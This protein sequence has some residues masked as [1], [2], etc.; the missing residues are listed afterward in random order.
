MLLFVI[1]S[2]LGSTIAVLSATSGGGSSGAGAPDGT[3]EQV[4]HGDPAPP[5]AGQVTAR[6]GQPASFDRTV[7][8][9]IAS[10]DQWWA[11]QL[12]ELYGLDYEPLAGGVWGASPGRELPPCGDLEVTYEDVAENAFFCPVDD[13]VV[14]DAESLIPDLLDRYGEAAVGVVLAHEWAHAIQVRVAEDLAKVDQVVLEL[15]ADCFAGGW[16]DHVSTTPASALVTDAGTRA[17][18]RAVLE[19]RDPLGV[20]SDDPDAHGS[21][22]DR[23]SA[24]QD[25]FVHGPGAC[26]GY[27]DDPP[28]TFQLPWNDYSDYV[29]D[30]NLPVAELLPALAEAFTDYAATSQDR[31]AALVL[32]ST[33]PAAKGCMIPASRLVTW[34]EQARAT[35]VDTARAGRL[36]EEVGDMAVGFVVAQTHF[37]QDRPVGLCAAGRWVA[38][39]YRDTLAGSQGFVL[40]P[41]DLDEI[42]ELILSG[43]PPITSGLDDLT[44]VFRTLTTLRS[45]LLDGGCPEV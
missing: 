17:A 6:Y 5:V 12:P 27:L 4:P 45:I 16:L 1:L 43:D 10:N 28:A 44:T 13:R 8:T 15:Q 42:V 23:M 33:D 2:V 40:S 37:A 25:G 38:A 26:V 7:D 9:F 39:V 31:E 32:A 18:F 3:I 41:G 11:S 34:C 22:F 30:G 21:A 19:I 14:Y 29:N 24:M 35:V 36:I 20:V